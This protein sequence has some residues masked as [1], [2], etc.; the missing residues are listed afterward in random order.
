MGESLKFAQKKPYDLIVGLS[1]Q[2]VSLLK[3]N[4]KRESVIIIEKDKSMSHK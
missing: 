3:N 1:E 4:Y 2:N